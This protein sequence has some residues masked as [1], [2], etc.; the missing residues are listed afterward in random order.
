MRDTVWSIVLTQVPIAIAC[1]LVA[2]ELRAVRSALDRIAAAV[3]RI[4]SSS[5]DEQR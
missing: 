4:S 1:F 5:K 2:R 3:E